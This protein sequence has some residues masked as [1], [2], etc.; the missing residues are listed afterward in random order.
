MKEWKLIRTSDNYLSMVYFQDDQ[1]EFNHSFGA[2]ANFTWHSRDLS[3]R[4]HNDVQRSRRAEKYPSLAELGDAI[5]HQEN[6][7]DVPMQNY[8]AK[9]QT[10]KDEFPLVEE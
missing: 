1:P 10:V 9:C 4:E 6:G 7:N 5:F 2:E 3:A 8:L